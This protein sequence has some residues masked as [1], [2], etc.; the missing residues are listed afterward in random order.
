MRIDRKKIEN[1]MDRLL[2]RRKKI[3]RQ[4]L[5]SKNLLTIV[6]VELFS[7]VGYRK[8]KCFSIVSD[9]LY[10]IGSQEIPKLILKYAGD[11]FTAL[12]SAKQTSMEQTSAWQNS[13]E[14]TSMGLRT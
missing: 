9:V 5:H 1:G 4:P 10:L 13:P 14:Q 3:G 12:P 7:E 6:L 8:E 11:F 2:A